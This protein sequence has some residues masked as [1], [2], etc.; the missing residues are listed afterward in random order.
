LANLIEQLRQ[1]DQFHR[2]LVV[3]ISHDLRTPLTSL[4]G[5]VETLDLKGETMPA[6][7]RERYLGIISANL[8]HLDR[9]INH[10]LQLSELDS[11]HAEFHL[12]DF[13]LEEL[14]GEVLS[15]FDSL[16]TERGVTLENRSD[17]NLPPVHADPLQIGQ[18]LQNLVD[19]GI[20][21][22]EPGGRVTVDLRREDQS[23]A[24]EV[25]DTGRGIAPEDL[26]HIFERFYTVDKSRSLKGQSS[27]LGLAIAQ[28]ILAGH[29]LELAVDSRLGKGS[30]FRFA[31]PLVGT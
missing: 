30:T 23:V 8:D 29:G 13:P 22:C 31:L 10:L 25:R 16:A 26:P 19:N 2:Q 18:V 21:F 27:G 14:V 5:Y 15:R 7:E 6:A 3:N 1:S 12:E 4:R 28:M 9:L 20:K 24:I 11:G 17:E